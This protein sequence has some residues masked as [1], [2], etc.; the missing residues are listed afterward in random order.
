MQKVT[1]GLQ[2]N[3]DILEKKQSVATAEITRLYERL[4]QA[5][6]AEHESHQRLESINN[7]NE[8]LQIHL[9]RENKKRKELETEIKAK[10]LELQNTTQAIELLRVRSIE[11]SFQN[12][13]VSQDRYSELKTLVKEQASHL[14]GSDAISQ[15][16]Q[17]EIERLIKRFDLRYLSKH[18]THLQFGIEKS[19][20]SILCNARSRKRDR[21][22]RTTSFADIR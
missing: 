21:I 15:Q 4:Q 10:D 8:A 1:M 16:K 12:R 17:E 2:A 6:I 5:S 22:E 9:R 19:K 14:N 20:P 7:K 18:T 3:V 11:R 13:F